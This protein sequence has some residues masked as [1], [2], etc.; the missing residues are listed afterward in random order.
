MQGVNDFL[1]IPIGA[2]VSFSY[3]FT[4]LQSGQ[5]VS[6]V[7]TE[8]TTIPASTQTIG[9]GRNMPSTT[10]LI[11]AETITIPVNVPPDLEPLMLPAD[12]NQTINNQFVF[13][14]QNNSGNYSLNVNALNEEEM[15]GTIQGTGSNTAFMNA[16]E[17]VQEN[18]GYHVTESMSGSGITADLY[19]T[20]G[21][22]I[23]SMVTPYNAMASN[24]TI[25]LITNNVDSAVIFKDL[26]VQAL[27]NATPSPL[28]NEKTANESGLLFPYVIF[29]I[30]LVV[31]S[32]VVLVYVK[33]RRMR[34]K[35]E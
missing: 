25:M 31:I 2:A 20:N 30:L 32:S 22:L 12:F 11:P 7:Q 17:N 35:P 18:A 28:S 4:I 9:G 6:N 8:T 19:N 29:W 33:K 13:I 27:N 5:T 21:T 23:D 24:E 10:I 3:D 1:S 14:L 26:T 34:I 16:S 15:S